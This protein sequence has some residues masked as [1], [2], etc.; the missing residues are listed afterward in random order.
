[1][2]EY[3]HEHVPEQ[4]NRWLLKNRAEHNKLTNEQMQ[5]ELQRLTQ[6]ELILDEQFKIKQE[7]QINPNADDHDR[8]CFDPLSQSADIE[9]Y[10]QLFVSETKE[11]IEEL[12]FNGHTEC[13]IVKFVSDAMIAGTPSDTEKVAL[14]PTMHFFQIVSASLKRSSWGTRNSWTCIFS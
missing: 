4:W 1:L 14:G 8:N 10:E 11:K 13:E 5:E 9:E 12:M 2:N 6:E 7:A 3:L